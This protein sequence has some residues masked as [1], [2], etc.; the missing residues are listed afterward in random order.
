MRLL[1]PATLLLLTSLRGLA[2]ELAV[3]D[4][5]SIQLA[6]RLLAKQHKAAYAVTTPAGNLELA[7]LL[8]DAASTDAAV[9]YAE[10]SEGERLAI[11]GLDLAL[12]QSAL[13][14][15]VLAYDVDE[16]DA[17]LAL[18]KAATA[19]FKTDEQLDNVVQAVAQCYAVLEADARTDKEAPLVALATAVSRK[20]KDKDRQQALKDQLVT[21]KAKLAASTKAQDEL[22]AKILAWA[23][24]KQGTQVGNGEC[25]DFV[26]DAIELNGGQRVEGYT[27][28]RRLRPGETPRNGDLL[29]L[30]NVEL[31]DGT[32]TF[33]NHVA[34]IVKV[35][36]PTKFEC[37]HSNWVNVKTVQPI[38]FDLTK[39]LAGTWTVYRARRAK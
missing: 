15:R 5:A 28:G 26:Y 23:V 22:Q 34:L 3:P 31:P 12:A 16:A 8:I 37:L 29:R 27:M 11:R 10:L 6:L 14:K 20:L 17:H 2:G 13:A 36:T 32:V 35:V 4:D 18:I 24:P 33:P 19:T 9:R 38:T 30:Q 39:P 7:R 21:L 1:R 25:T